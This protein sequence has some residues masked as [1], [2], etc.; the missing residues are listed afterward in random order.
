MTTYLPDFEAKAK[1]ESNIIK[2]AAADGLIQL[3]QETRSKVEKILDNGF[4]IPRSDLLAEN[5]SGELATDRLYEGRM[6]LEK[7]INTVKGQV[8]QAIFDLLQSDALTLDTLLHASDKVT[9]ATVEN[10]YVLLKRRYYMTDNLV[11]DVKRK[12][13]VVYEPSRL[14]DYIMCAHVLNDHVGFMNLHNELSTMYANITQT[15][16]KLVCSF[17][18]K[19]NQSGEQINLKKFKHENIHSD[20]MPL[21][22]CHIEIFRPFDNKDGDA[23]SSDE[24]KIE[25]KY[26]Y[27]LYCR[28]Y[29]SRY[30]WMEPLT[31]FTFDEL[32]P[33][34]TKLLFNMIRL[35]IFIDTCTLDR[36]D[37]FDVCEHIARSYKI[38]L[39]LG[40]NSS[41]TFQ[42][43]GIKR[44]RGL[45]LQN[46]S[47]C[48]KDWNMCLKLIV[49]R[50][51]QNYSDRV[52]GVPSDLLCSNIPVLHRRFRTQQR[53]V[54]AQLMGHHVVQFKEAG[55]MI[56][57][58]D[59]NS[60]NILAEEGSESDF[61]DE[62]EHDESDNVNDAILDTDLTSAKKRRKKHS[63]SG[64]KK[65]HKRTESKNDGE[66]REEY[67]ESREIIPPPE[68]YKTVNPLPI[69]TEPIFNISM[70]L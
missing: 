9:S 2:E 54:I 35:P 6:Q 47:E 19:C 3:H 14:F 65:K 41:T 50:V 34:I 40:L 43:N 32:L 48:L 63:S 66:T 23:N 4:L 51:N 59:E 52:R 16:C 58:E 57:L 13:L 11:F 55:G 39:G 22:R 24:L 33:S 61:D 27:V 12:N 29:F 70:E 7:E 15:I 68:Q 30:I 60:S 31:G 1:S 26:P 36:Q 10:K 53:R 21:G 64:R 49:Q 44:I 5:L 38:K 37:M 18:S 25:G 62:N 42:R 28:D 17:C 67:D 45:F 20:M 69:V 8:T 56:Y 46:K